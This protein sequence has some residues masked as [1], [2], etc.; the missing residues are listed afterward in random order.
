MQVFFLTNKLQLWGRWIN[1]HEGAGALL[2]IAKIKAKKEKARADSLVLSTLKATIVCSVIFLLL[3]PMPVSITLNVKASKKLA[4]LRTAFNIPPSFNLLL[5]VLYENTLDKIWIPHKFP[6]NT[7]ETMDDTTQKHTHSWKNRT[8]T[9]T[10]ECETHGINLT[11]QVQRRQN[12]DET[13]KLNK[14]PFFPPWVSQSS[15][16]RCCYVSLKVVFLARWLQWCLNLTS[17]RRIHWRRHKNEDT[18]SV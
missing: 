11:K 3:S 14:S 17:N 5:P 8:S 13:L 12:T 4:T 2:V 18:S 1:I 7:D 6:D 9:T 16:I 10:W 15:G